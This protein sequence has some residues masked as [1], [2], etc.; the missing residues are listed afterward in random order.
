[1]EEGRGLSTLPYW[2]RGEGS[3]LFQYGRGE[4]DRSPSILEE[5]RGLSTLSPL[6]HWKK[7][8]ALCS[9]FSFE[10]RGE[11]GAFYCFSHILSIL[12]I[13]QS[14][15]YASKSAGYYSDISSS[16]YARKRAQESIDV[17]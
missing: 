5:G 4:R 12:N 2:K 15:N 7:S 14:D 16:L 6:P 3:L 11:R 9:P 17:S 1:M 13:P 8:W 10:R